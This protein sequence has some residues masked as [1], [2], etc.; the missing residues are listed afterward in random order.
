MHEP[1]GFTVGPAY[2]MSG[3]GDHQTLDLSY[4]VICERDTPNERSDDGGL[5]R[6]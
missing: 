3:S 5:P 1:R 4:N 2:S 6:H